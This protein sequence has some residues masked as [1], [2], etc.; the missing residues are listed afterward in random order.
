MFVKALFSGYFF[1]DHATVDLMR[2][3]S[4]AGVDA[5]G[6][7]TIYGRGMLENN[8]FLGHGGQTLGFQS[9]GGYHPGADVTIVIWSNTATSAVNRLAVP[10]LAAIVLGE[11]GAGAAG[12][13][14]AAAPA[15]DSASDAPGDPVAALQAA[16]GPPSQA[17]FGSAVFYEPQPGDADLEALA[18]E[19]YKYFVGD[20]WDRYGEAA[21]MGPW[22]QVYARPAGATPDIVAEL[23]A[24][25]DFDAS[26]SVPMILEAVDEAEQARAALSAVYDDPAMAEVAVYTLGDGGAMSGLLV[27][28]RRTTGD[29]VFLVFL[30]D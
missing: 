9:D 27:A 26:L 21:W 2:G 7:G 18:L 11:G 14:A 30:L 19:K 24:I 23:S 20:L 22:R 12:E 10:G 4:D 16:Y 6:P 5:L 25:D 3:H 15:P 13:D 29:A 1:Q 28:G 17:A 8:G